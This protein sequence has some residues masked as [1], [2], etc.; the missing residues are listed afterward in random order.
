MTAITIP[1][2]QVLLL[3]AVLFVLGLTGVL[4][5][6]NVIF[7]LMSLEIMSLIAIRQS[8]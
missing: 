5:R 3:S 4:V 6:R 2:E 7:Q 8:E 1:L